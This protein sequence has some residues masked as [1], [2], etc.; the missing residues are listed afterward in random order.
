MDHADFEGLVMVATEHVLNCSY[1]DL[2]VLLRDL[3]SS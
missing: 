1:I 3:F 2:G